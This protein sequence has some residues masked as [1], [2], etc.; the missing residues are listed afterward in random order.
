[1]T[2]SIV[3]TTSDGVEI[4]G[5]YANTGQANI[6]LLFHMMPATKESWNDVVEPFL[7]IGYASIAIDLRGHGQSTMNGRLNYRQFMDEQH[8]A[9]QEDVEAAILFA[10]DQGFSEENMVLMG[11]SIGANL[12]IQALQKHSSILSAI[13]L[14]PGLDYHGINIESVMGQMQTNQKV[15]LV[16]SDDDA[17]SW[18]SIKQLRERYASQTASIEC[19]GCGHGTNMFEK[20]PDLTEK[21]FSFLNH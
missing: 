9:S 3:F 18:Y 1:M 17:Y 8:Q 21:I 16:A 4:H 14:S 15:L 2:Q 12:A 13:A 6:V 7:E 5:L 11:A 20:D 19:S 10:K